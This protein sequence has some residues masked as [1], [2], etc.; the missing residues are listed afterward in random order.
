MDEMYKKLSNAK[1]RISQKDLKEWEEGEKL[2]KKGLDILM[3]IS[4]GEDLSQTWG[5]RYMIEGIKILAGVNYNLTKEIVENDYLFNHALKNK[6][7]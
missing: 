7:L 1:A 2:F 4:V 3:R 5:K 6:E